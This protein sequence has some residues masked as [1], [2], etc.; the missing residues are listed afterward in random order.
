MAAVLDTHAAIWHLKTTYFGFSDL[1]FSPDARKASMSLESTLVRVPRDSFRQNA[2]LAT[3]RVFLS[4]KYVPSDCL[5]FRTP[6]W[7]R[8]CSSFG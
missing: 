5:G 6:N 7:A 2:T 8:F 4:N 1:S 3:R